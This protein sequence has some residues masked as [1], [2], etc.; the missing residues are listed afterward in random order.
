MACKMMCAGGH[1]SFELGQ[2][3]GAAADYVADEL[4]CPAG[5]TMV[6][7]CTHDAPGT[8]NCGVN[9]AIRLTCASAPKPCSQLPGRGCDA[10]SFDTCTEC[11]PGS[12]SAGG[13][14][15]PHCVLCAA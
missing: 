14:P 9:E 13:K 4:T 12:A 3:P 5:A 8:H 1:V 15:N 2:S 11:A 6:E 10:T 7:E